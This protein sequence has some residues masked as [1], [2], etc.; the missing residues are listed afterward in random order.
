MPRKR[1]PRSAAGPQTTKQAYNPYDTDPY[2]PL[3]NPASRTKPPLA[4]DDASNE[5]PQP[6]PNQPPSPPRP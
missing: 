3:N 4:R 2:D 5:N 1:L 6:R